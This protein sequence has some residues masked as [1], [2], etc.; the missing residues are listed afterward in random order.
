M[1]R[2]G[3]VPRDQETRELIR[4]TVVREAAAELVDRL[5]SRNWLVERDEV[6]LDTF[7]VMNLTAPF[8]AADLLHS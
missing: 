7:V 3:G 8:D 5:P 4:T 2:T 6:V 1:V